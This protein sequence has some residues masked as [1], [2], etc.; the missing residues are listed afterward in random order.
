MAFE[1]TMRLRPFAPADEAAL[2]H[3][4]FESWMSVGLTS[5][6]V[7]RAELAERVPRELAGRWDVTVAER[8]GELLGFVALALE[9]NRLDQIFITPDA[10]G[11][12]VGSLLFEVACQKMPH[13]FWLSTQPGNRRACEFYERAGMVLDCLDTTPAGERLVYRFRR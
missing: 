2:A 6:S 8:D 11:Q 12:G 1:M 4:W 13:G 7:T 10:Q 9:E 5:P 3:L